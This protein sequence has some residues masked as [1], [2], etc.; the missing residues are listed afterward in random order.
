MRKLTFFWIVA[1]WVIALKGVASAGPITTLT[2]LVSN[3]T[4]MFAV[5]V[6][7]EAND[8]SSLS[9]VFPNVIS[10][11][12]CNYSF[13]SCTAAV[14]GQT[15][16]LGLTDPGIVFSLTDLTAPNVFRTDALASD[17][18]AHSLVSNTVDASDAAAVAAAYEIFGQGSLPFAAAG[19]IAT[20]G[21]FPETTLTFVGWEDR[22]GLDYDYNDMI[23]AFTDPP[24]AV[25]E[26]ST[27]LL[28]GTGLLG[29][30][31]VRRR[32]KA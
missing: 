15:V 21:L 4:Q 16:D 19:A 25:P 7:S 22:I 28:F 13:G 30:A 9:E 12:F 8:T 20:L 10:D 29:L 5:Y 1:A 14:V 3:G 27:I 6:F 18:Y 32:R 23:F 2:P 31:A 26:P 24:T 17:G 11:I